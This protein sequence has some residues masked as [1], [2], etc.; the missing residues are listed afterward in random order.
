MIQKF[1]QNKVEMDHQYH[2]YQSVNNIFSNLYWNDTIAL[3]HD[4]NGN[5]CALETYSYKVLFVKEALHS[6]STF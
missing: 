3:I 6:N 5:R 1:V 2:Q 4:M